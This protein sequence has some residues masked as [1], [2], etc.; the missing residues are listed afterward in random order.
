[1]AFRVAIVG[2]GRIGLELYRRAKS[3]ELDIVFMLDV[4]GMYKDPLKKEKIG[5]FEDYKKQ[6]DSLDLAF[7]TIPTS[8]N[9]ETAYN[10][11][12]HFLSL[13][14]PI[15]TSEKG[16]LS[17]HFSE[18][19]FAIKNGM[20]GYSATVGGGTRLLNYLEGRV[21]TQV[22]EIHAV[23]N[24]TLN[25]I[26]TG[27]S[28]GR[29]LG[30]VVEETKKLG[31]AEPGADNPI[32]VINKEATG[33]VPMKTSILFNICNLTKERMRARDVKTHKIDDSELGRLIEESVRRR[34]IVSITK[35]NNHEE[36][37]IWG[38]KHNVGEWYI[39]AGFKDLKKN[40]LFKKLVPNG[41]DNAVLISEGRH[42]IDGNYV[43]SGPGAGPGPTTAS[44]MRDA[45]KILL[46]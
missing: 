28:E 32:D 5:N 42:G 37:V 38:F 29:S 13:S 26:F 31:Y 6:T 15:V 3:R 4:D 35:Y 30:E 14:T 16:A 1:M 19:D 46:R 43:L 7:L 25:Y 40:P 33:D 2:M 24:G 36:D 22:E 9:G 8:D 20:I 27:L 21:T 45:V 41:V 39:S 17:N 34:Y 12:N 18:L 23:V 11:M 10:Y 44:M